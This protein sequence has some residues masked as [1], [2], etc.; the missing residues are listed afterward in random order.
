MGKWVFEGKVYLVKW[1]SICF[2]KSKL[3][4]EG[5]GAALVEGFEV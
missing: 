4:E 3:G 1:T 5:G 2:S